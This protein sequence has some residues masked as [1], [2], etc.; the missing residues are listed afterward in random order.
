[1]HRIS[2]A[3]IHFCFVAQFGR[4]LVEMYLSKF[5]AQG[6]TQNDVI[7]LALSLSQSWNDSLQTSDFVLS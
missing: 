4:N 2:D 5:H 3:K 7:S 6:P 1:M